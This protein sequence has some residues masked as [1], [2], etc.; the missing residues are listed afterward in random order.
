MLSYFFNI[1]YNE[2]DIQEVLINLLYAV[3]SIESNK[4]YLQPLLIAGIYVVI[5]LRLLN[6]YDWFHDALRVLHAF[7]QNACHLRRILSIF[8]RAY[9]ELKKEEI[10]EMN[11][12]DEND[13]KD[14]KDE[15]DEEDKIDEK[16]EKDEKEN[17][18]ENI[19][20]EE[21][22]FFEKLQ[23]RKSPYVSEDLGLPPAKRNL[24]EFVE[25]TMSPEDLLKHVK[26][27]VDSDPTIIVC[28]S[29]KVD[30]SI[31][32]IADPDHVNILDMSTDDLKCSLNSNNISDET[33]WSGF[34][35]S[36]NSD[37][38]NINLDNTFG[39][40]SSHESQFSSASQ[41][42][43]VLVPDL[44]TFTDSETH[45]LINEQSKPSVSDESGY[46]SASSMFVENIENKTLPEE[47]YNS[48]TTNSTSSDVD[49][50]E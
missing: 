13:I 11:K 41:D 20:D 43:S 10:H 30:V 32:G 42:L 7:L 28:E 21:T 15:E 44:V 27:I 3:F 23:C 1:K 5:V 18:F 24:N 2:V 33:I 25:Y 29:D 36:E 47:L 26:F 31:N 49:N 35:E 12:K 40:A 34:G 19:M 50:I 17:I 9:P 39:M 6:T 22:I 46:K 45:T 38:L 8:G 4:K 48:M 14:E 16:D 37:L